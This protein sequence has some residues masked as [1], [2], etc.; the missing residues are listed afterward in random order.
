MSMTI[1]HKV[2]CVKGISIVKDTF[3]GKSNDAKS[4]SDWR[5]WTDCLAVTDKNGRIMG[6]YEKNSVVAII[7][8]KR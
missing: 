7:Y 5:D 3:C 6:S 2:K 1:Y 4:F 8:P